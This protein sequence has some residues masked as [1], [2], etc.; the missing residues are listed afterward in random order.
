MIILLFSPSIHLLSY[1]YT[2]N[3]SELY[4]EI[5]FLDLRK[6]FV[7]LIWKGGGG[8]VWL[9]VLKYI[10]PFQIVVDHLGA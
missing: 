2:A 9:L 7:T 8:G 4:T 10:T 6:M 1:A 5:Y 3:A